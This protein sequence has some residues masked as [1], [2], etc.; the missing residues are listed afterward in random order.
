MCGNSIKEGTEQC[1]DGNTEPN[2]GCDLCVTK[3]ILGPQG[4]PPFANVIP[5][6]TAVIIKTWGVIMEDIGIGGNATILG[7]LGVIGDT[8][9][10]A[11]LTVGANANIT[12]DVNVAGKAVI[13][14]SDQLIN[15]D[16]DKKLAGDLVIYDDLT[17]GACTGSGGTLAG[18]SPSSKFTGSLMTKILNIGNLTNTA[19]NNVLNNTGFLLVGD[20]STTAWNTIPAEFKGDGDVVFGGDL[21]VGASA[22][23]GGGKIRAQSVGTYYQVKSVPSLSFATVGKESL[24]YLVCNEFDVLVGCSADFYYDNAA[25]RNYGTRIDSNSQC[26]AHVKNGAGA[27]DTLTMYLQCFD[28]QGV[29]TGLVQK[30]ATS[31]TQP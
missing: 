24:G 5:N 29:T 20:V 7:L 30:A 28:P 19:F 21:Y 8:T 23:T 4:D 3:P 16:A 12:G 1:D 11:N 15:V 31:W 18:C 9:L 6:F 27:A 13:G 10:S 2:D 17:V 26:T 25:D 14:G 22:G